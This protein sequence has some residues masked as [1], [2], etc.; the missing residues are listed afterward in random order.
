[1][2]LSC[3]LHSFVFLTVIDSRLSP[4]VYLAGC[5]VGVYCMSTFVFSLT[6]LYASLV[7]FLA[8][9]M[10]LRLFFLLVLFPESFLYHAFRAEGDSSA[11]LF[12]GLLVGLSFIAWYALLGGNLVLTTVLTFL[13]AEVFVRSLMLCLVQ[14]M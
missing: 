6:P 9:E 7:T 2:D 11:K 13:T 5:S 8:A 12:A 10:S 3:L 4:K 14:G 1:M